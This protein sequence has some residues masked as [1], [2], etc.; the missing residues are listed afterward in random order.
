MDIIE[1]PKSKEMFKSGSVEWK[2]NNWI[3]NLKY[4]YEKHGLPNGIEKIQSHCFRVT[5]ATEMYEKTKDIVL[6]SR[7]LGHKNIKTT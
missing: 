5:R 7:Y 4:F 6:V 3:M 1:D 2:T